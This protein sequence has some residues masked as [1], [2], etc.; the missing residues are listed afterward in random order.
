MVHSVLQYCINT[1]IFLI[2]AN[3]VSIL[4]IFKKTSPPK[5][6]DQILSKAEALE[7]AEVAIAELAPVKKEEKHT[8]ITI[9]L[10][11]SPV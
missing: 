11:T 5:L 3:A 1:V 10:S 6:W 7:T 8:Q 2:L 4:V 9:I